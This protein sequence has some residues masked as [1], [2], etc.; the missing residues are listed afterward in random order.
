[1]RSG[2]SNFHFVF[3]QYKFI[4]DFFRLEFCSWSSPQDDNEAECAVFSTEHSVF[5]YGLDSPSVN[6]RISERKNFSLGILFL[7]KGNI[8][9]HSNPCTA[10]AIEALFTLHETDRKPLN[11]VLEM[12]CP[13]SQ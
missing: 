8:P 2:S 11:T 1:M 5:F 3:H 6:E 9:E 4:C 10:L 12:F 13:E 7:L